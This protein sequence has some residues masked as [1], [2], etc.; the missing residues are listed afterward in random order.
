[1]R[2]LLMGCLIIIILLAGCASTIPTVVPSAEK[3]CPR[4]VRPVI[5]QRASW[6]VQGLLEMNLVVIDY[7]LKLEKTVECWEK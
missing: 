3:Y 2:R 4:P 1:M 5:E 7:T 6:D